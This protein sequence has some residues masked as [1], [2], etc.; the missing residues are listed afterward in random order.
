M[1]NKNKYVHEDESVLETAYNNFKVNK[2]HAN[3]PLQQRVRR[4]LWVE[5][6]PTSKPTFDPAWCS[7]LIYSKEVG[8]S[9][10]PHWQGY[11]RLKSPTNL[12]KM[13]QWNKRAFFCAVR[14]TEAQNITY[15]SKNPIEG[16]FRFGEEEK[17]GKRSDLLLAIDAINDGDKMSEIAKNNP[18]V[19]VR[20]YKGLQTY[21]NITR[22][23]SHID[24]EAF[25][26]YYIWGPT[27]VGKTKYVYDTVAIENLYTTIGDCTWWDGYDHQT[28]ILFDEFVGQVPLH[29]MLKYLDRYLMMLPTKGS[30][31]AKRWYRVYITS[32]VSPD[33]QYIVCHREQKAAFL[34]RLTNVVHMTEPIITNTIDFNQLTL[35]DPLTQQNDSTNN[36]ITISLTAQPEDEIVTEP[37]TPELIPDSPF[38]AL[39]ATIIRPEDEA[40]L[41]EIKESKRKVKR[42]RK[43]NNNNKKQ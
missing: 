7:F 30:H 26:V 31:V 12:T 4:W 3:N 11:I 42:L 27:G 25:S 23:M 28:V 6:N 18:E 41:A 16:P 40:L 8:D 14:G 19:F 43:N 37:C 33:E 38:S 20:Y 10:T 15:I 22:P 1:S 13:K 17:P 34:R 32:N 29:M 2:C 24:H 21:A 36:E 5:N 35:I 9:G 39:A